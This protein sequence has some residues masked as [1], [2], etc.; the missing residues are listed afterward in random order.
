MSDLKIPI[1][2]ETLSSL[3]GKDA[4]S[5]KETF[6]GELKEG[7][8][9]KIQD[10]V[11]PDKTVS[12]LVGLKMKADREN[13]YGRGKKE[14]AQD[15]EKALKEKGYSGDLQGVE[16]LTAYLDSLK[17]SNPK[18]EAKPNEVTPEFLDGSEIAKQWFESNFESK[19]KAM[20]E[21]NSQKLSEIESKYIE[22]QQKNQYSNIREW[23]HKTLNGLKWQ[24]GKDEGLTD[25]RLDQMML[26][27]KNSGYQLK[28]RDGEPPLVL[29]KEGNPAKDN[30]YFNDIDFESLAKSVNTYGY[31]KYDKSQSPSGK[32]QPGEKGGSGLVITSDDQYKKLRDEA[33]KIREVGK[34]AQEFSKIN[35]AY[36][37]FKAKG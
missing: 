36:D 17:Q 23:L 20:K 26:S 5:L 13:Q 34:R 24:D 37:E 30:K 8:E 18:G 33:Y 7:E 21:E 15:F 19:V 32:D 11:N 29:D 10:G 35:K 14:T 12:E 28:A 25:G 3:T 4:D 31:R 22:L 27:L 2:I 9:V 6:F 1:G 16:A